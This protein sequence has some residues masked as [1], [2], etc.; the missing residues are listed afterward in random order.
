MISRAESVFDIRSE[1]PGCV[2][3]SFRRL[4]AVAA[5]LAISTSA[6]ASAPCAPGNGGIRLPEGFCAQ[7]VAD[8]LGPARHLAVNANGDVYVALLR[9]GIV[10]LRDTNGDGRAEIAKRFGSRGGTGIGIHR[11]FLYFATE[12][13]VV[14]YSLKKN[15]LL[16][17]GPPQ[18]VASGFPA[19]REHAQKNFAFDDSGNL[20]VN[21][22]APSNACQKRPRTPGSPGFDPCPQRRRQAG[23][24]RF[25]ADATG[26]TQLCD[27]HRFAA[28]LRN[29]VALAWDP[30]AGRLYAVQHGRDQ[31]HQLWPG[32]YT[33]RQGAE[34]PAEEFLR[35]RDGADFGW[36]YCYYD[37]NLHKMVL[38]PEYGGNGKRAGRCGS[39][40]PPL[41]AFPGHWAPDGLLFYTGGQFPARYRGGAF[42]AFHGSWNR[43]PLRQQGY[44]VVFVPFRDGRPAGPWEVFADGFAGPGPIMSPAEARFRPV[45]LA[46]GPD[47]SLYISDS[48][49][50]RIWRVMYRRFR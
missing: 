23:I 47:G 11:H 44:K 37:Q 49:H 7:V 41:M 2:G 40:D 1:H 32:L 12:T 14:R 31:L 45:G 19:Q 21:V 39:F 8:D 5:M 16:P 48:V 20:Y 35:V 28:G 3:K 30:V 17:S 36:P 4:L 27:G 10:A 18:T 29:A 24:W 33:P 50:G 6:L 42:I 13:A 22:G 38:A 46:Q 34:L 25:R 43:A 9:G 15:K 26:Q